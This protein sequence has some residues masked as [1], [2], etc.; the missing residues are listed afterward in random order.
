LNNSDR[1]RLG[2]ERKLIF[3]NYANGVGIEILM[4]AFKRSKLEI[5]REIVWPV[6]PSGRRLS[7]LLRPP[8]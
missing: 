6:G 5:E 4:V 8:W 2:E 3:E 1:L 7:G